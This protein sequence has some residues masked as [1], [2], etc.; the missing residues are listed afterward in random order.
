MDYFDL[1][2]HS[3]KITT[4]SADAQRWFDR[5]LVWCYGY[6]HEEA[7][8]CFE[9]AL[10]ADPGCAM[11]HWGV[12]YGAGPNYNMPWDLFDDAGRAAAL[13]RAHA[14]TEAAQGLAV[15]VTPAE[16]A[17]IAA[18]T[19]RY[20]QAEPLDD[21]Q[22]WNDAFA[23]AM[24]AAHA[25]HPDDPEIATI[26][27]EAMMN[28]TPWKMWDQAT[29]L[30]ADGAD[31]VEARRVLE[32]ALA[33]I[34]GAMDHPGLLH[35]YVHLMEMSPFPEQALIVA[36]RL[37]DLVPDAGHLVHMPTHIDIQCGHYRDALYWNQKAIEAD[38]K[39]LAREGPMNIYSGY[40]VHNYHFAVYGA[41]FLGQFAPALAAA[42]ELIATIPEALLRIDSP[43]MADYFESYIAVRPHVFIRFGRWHEILAL[44]MPDDPDLYCNLVATL[45]YAR[46]IAHAALGQVPRAEAEQVAF[47]AAA[48]RVPATRLLHNN[49]CID[50]LAVAEKML[51]GEIAYRKGEYDR[52]FADLREAV[53]REDML[54]YDE[55]WG[56][57]QPVRHAL[58][59]LLLEQGHVDQA[60]AV[61]RADLGLGERLPRAQV[62]PDNLWS[63]RGLMD[64]LTRSGAADTAE[65]RLIGQRL[66][67]VAARADVP[68]G[69]SCFCAGQGGDGLSP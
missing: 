37:R 58:G 43:P 22:A 53:A 32:D 1:G 38:R 3:R 57:M 52:A 4:G 48:A 41:M 42:D 26:F 56:W 16:R 13:G 50:L 60:E 34:P 14:A 66:E 61:Y 45:H 21:M 25:A 51:S 23:D 18:L 6:N 40:R 12:A 17:L 33:R 62:H 35:L 30:P 19:S 9:K 28:R 47:R 65:G 11:A 31:T 10:V 54:P 5:G 8:A 55:P 20:P 44:P 68:V 39:Y 69:V 46:G 29:G 49:R 67:L 24:R 64:C 7:V 63:L 2:T 15:G 27:V 59:A 36:D